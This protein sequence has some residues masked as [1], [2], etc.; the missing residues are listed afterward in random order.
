MK[1]KLS[2]MANFAE[3]IAAVAVVVSLIYVGIQV[4]DTTRAVRAAAANDANVAM[5]SW[6]L[7]IGNNRQMSDLFI[8]TMRN[9]DDLSIEDEFQ[10]L[11][12]FHAVFLGFQNSYLLTQEGALDPSITEAITTAVLGVKDLPGFDLYWRQRRDYLHPGFVAYI[13]DLRNRDTIDTVDI[14]RIQESESQ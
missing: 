10:F 6:Y 13:E 2:D 8:N 3:I 4:N 9:T 1:L 14:Y 12:T 11:M 5:Q 7:T